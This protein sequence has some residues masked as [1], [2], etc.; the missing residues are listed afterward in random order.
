MT[1]QL[2]K[3]AARKDIQTALSV[4]KNE[5]LGPSLQIG[6]AYSAAEVKLDKIRKQLS[7]LLPR[8]STHPFAKHYVGRSEFD[9]DK[10]VRKLEPNVIRCRDC[11]CLNAS[12]HLTKCYSCYS[13]SDEKGPEVEEKN[14]NMKLL[15][16]CAVDLQIQMKQVLEVINRQLLE[17]MV[18]SDECLVT[19]ADVA[20]MTVA[21]IPE[22]T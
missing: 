2:C 8:F 16:T 21:G 13:F 15:E 14:P 11:H 6:G 18:A 22:R 17:K 20:H 1:N 19:P 7:L 4:L 3:C 10:E 9:A 12:P 5:C